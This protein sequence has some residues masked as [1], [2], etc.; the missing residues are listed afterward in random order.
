MAF[1]L[2]CLP[3][4]RLANVAHELSWE[5]FIASAFLLQ[6]W[7]FHSSAVWNI[8]AWSLCAEAFSYLWFPLLI[9]GAFTLRS[10]W[11]VSILL[12]GVIGL[13]GFEITFLH[14]LSQGLRQADLGAFPH[15]LAEFTGGVLLYRLY[16]LAKPSNRA[17]VV[18]DLS[19]ATLLVLGLATPY[20]ILSV[21][22]FILIVFSCAKGG[23]IGK[24]MAH[25]VCVTLGEIS[26]SLYLSHW[27]VIEILRTSLPDNAFMGHG[28]AFKL[29]A[30]L[31]SA[32]IILAVA[33]ILWRLVEYPSHVLAKMYRRRAHSQ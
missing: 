3:T 21:Y 32:G 14:G 22:A 20:A 26:F 30:V 6:I 15:C 23:P 13:L 7:I 11:T 28:L 31:A 10:L 24:I 25:P 2:W 16:E 29:T 5:G 4:M 8:P 1:A 27:I 9:M 18:F 17:L 12:V 19:A 33:A